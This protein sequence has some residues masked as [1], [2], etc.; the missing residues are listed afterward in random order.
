MRKSG[1]LHIILEIVTILS[2]I[3]IGVSVLT[4]IAYQH[5]ENLDLNKSFIGS[6]VL[7]IGVT[8][9][10]EFLSLKTLATLEPGRD[11]AVGQLLADGRQGHDSQVPADAGTERI[12]DGFADAGEL[13]LL[14]EERAAQDG[15]V[16][17]DQGQE[18]AQGGVEGGEE[19]LHHHLHHLHDGRD[20]RDEEDKAQETQVHLG[21][22]GAEPA[23]RAGLEDELVEE[24]VERKRAEEHE[25]H[26][27][28]QAVGRLHV[29]RYRQV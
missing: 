29:L 23:Q 7:A 24:V 6:V 28:A 8:E 17:G 11:V 14:H 26:S 22:L 5:Q 20:D 10:V 19:F 9:M 12:N 4:F 2:N 16:D 25:D 18:D 15:A 13:T 3:I 21:E 1:T 27:E